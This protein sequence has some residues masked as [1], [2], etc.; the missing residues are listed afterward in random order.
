LNIVAFFS[1]GATAQKLLARFFTPEMGFGTIVRADSTA[2]IRILFD[3]GDVA[4]TRSLGNA[5][6]LRIYT[7]ADTQ[8]RADAI[9]AMG[10]LSPNGIPRCMQKGRRRCMKSACCHCTGGPALR[11]G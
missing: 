3:N 1:A 2:G 8:V 5:D 11:L 4:Y 9:A 7:V 6:E 10:S